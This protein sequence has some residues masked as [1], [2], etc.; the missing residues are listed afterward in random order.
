MSHVMV[1]HVHSGI[2]Y[3][4][5]TTPHQSHPS[6]KL[7]LSSKPLT[8]QKFNLFLLALAINSKVIEIH[9]GHGDTLRIGLRCTATKQADSDN[10]D[11]KHGNEFAHGSLHR[12]VHFVKVDEEQPAGFRTSL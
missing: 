4:L 9:G 10:A 7:I 11:A 8:L 2:G 12:H 5:V 3:E 6:I 1:D